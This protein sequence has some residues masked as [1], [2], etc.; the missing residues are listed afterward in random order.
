MERNLF[1]TLEEHSMIRVKSENRIS[2]LEK[3]PVY[4]IPDSFRSVLIFIS[5]R[6]SVYI[7]PELSDT[8]RS[9]NCSDFY[10]A[11]DVIDILL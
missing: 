7:M 4:T 3:G 11:P 5:D 6:Y 10:S 1:I 2:V 8:K 9:K